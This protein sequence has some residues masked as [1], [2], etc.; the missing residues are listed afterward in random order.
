MCKRQAV[1]HY[2]TAMAVFK[3]WL[4]EGMISREELTKI[5]A[6][7]AQKYGLSIRSIYR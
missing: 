1:I 4:A 6:L 7:I 2:R 5:D 3:K